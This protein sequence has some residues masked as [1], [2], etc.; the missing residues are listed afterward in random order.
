MK[1]RHSVFTFS[2]FALAI[3]ACDSA[4]GPGGN[5]TVAFQPVSA[6]VAP[7]GLMLARS[8]TAAIPIPGS[9]GT[10]SIDELYLIVAEFELELVGV[11]CDGLLDDDCEEFEAPAAFVQV[12]M[13]AGVDQAVV[14]QEVP[15]GSYSGLE[16][17]VEDLEDD[18]EDDDAV[19]IQAV[20]DA[21]LAAGF[22]DWPSGASMLAVGSFTPTGG[23]AVPFRVFFD[24]EIE[25]ELDFDTPLEITEDAVDRTVSVTVDPTA[26][27]LSGDTVVDL[28]QWDYDT[29][30]Q[31]LEFGFELENG[32]TDVEFDDD[33]S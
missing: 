11:E 1:V 2:A 9:N 30:G 3:M 24:A 6:Q 14:R 25:I 8:G 13:E 19:A 31:L 17:E 16:F 28:S 27:F 29:T 4:T 5:V 26:W 15:A 23:S 21:I 32:F 12:P 18:E 10:L 20:R 33:D 7:S 22:D